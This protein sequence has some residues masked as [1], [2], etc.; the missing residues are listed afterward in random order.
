VNWGDDDLD[1]WTPND[2]PPSGTYKGDKDDD[3]ISGSGDD[4]FRLFS[5]FSIGVNPG[6][7]PVG[8]VIEFENNIKVW[9]TWTKKKWGEGEEWISSQV[10]SGS[11][12][13]VSEGIPYPLL[14][15]GQSGTQNFR[16]VSLTATVKYG[17]DEI[18]SD[19]V[20]I[21]VFEVTLAGLFAGA[22]QADCDKKHSTFKGSSDRNGK[23][24]WDDAN[25]DGVVGDNDPNCEYFRNCMECQGTVKPSGVTTTQAEF[26]FERDVWGRVWGKLPGEGFWSLAEVDIPW[27][28]D[29]WPDDRDEDNTPSAENHIYHIDSPG[30]TCKDQASFT[31][32]SAIADW[33]EC[34]WVNFGG[35]WYQCSNFYKWHS[36]IYVKPKNATELTRDAPA[37]QNLGGGWINVPTNP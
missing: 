6:W 36:Q 17:Q 2:N 31:H 21:T 15:E 35:E 7:A 22:Q 14:I 30:C 12:F 8:V 26:T 20:K 25:G 34:V 18:C 23:I 9:E 19:T 24:S 32:W 16:D 28:D 3:F 13:N 33:R 11:Q 27:Q 5:L 4:D 37:L 1:G 10:P 29:G